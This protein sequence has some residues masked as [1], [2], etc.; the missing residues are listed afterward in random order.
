MVTI[1]VPID[2]LKIRFEQGHLFPGISTTQV[3][4]FHLYNENAVL[5][6]M[7]RTL[8]L[9]TKIMGA[10]PILLLS[11]DPGSCV[12]RGRYHVWTAHSDDTVFK[13]VQEGT[14]YDVFMMRATLKPKHLGTA[15]AVHFPKSVSTP[16]LS[17]EDAV[18]VLSHALNS[19]TPSMQSEGESTPSQVEVE[20]E[21]EV[22]AQDLSAT[23]NISV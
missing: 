14:H 3:V 2:L 17:G 11:L 7:C 23:Y 12:K 10:K 20:V 6:N 19:Q 18:A 4:G 15:K 1:Y 16:L 21:V 22:E 5:T 9:K 13:I 8:F